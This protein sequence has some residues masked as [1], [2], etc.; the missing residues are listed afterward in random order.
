MTVVGC[1]AF[2]GAFCVL[3]ALVAEYKGEEYADEEFKR[4]TGETPGC[5]FAFTIVIT[6]LLIL[7]TLAGVV[8]R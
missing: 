5:F 3:Y 6:T 2:A 7:F 4:V 8:F 1:V